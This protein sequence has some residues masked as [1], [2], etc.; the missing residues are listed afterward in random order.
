[1]DDM[2]LTESNGLFIMD[3]KISKPF[4]SFYTCAQEIK[5]NGSV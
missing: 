3:K 5:P 4:G 1:M 2:L